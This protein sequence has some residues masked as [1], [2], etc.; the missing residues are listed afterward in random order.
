MQFFAEQEGEWELRVQLNTDLDKMPIEDASVEWP[1]DQSAYLPVARLRI[2]RQAAW[3]E[4][5]STATRIGCRSIRGTASTP[6]G[7]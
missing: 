6:T 2:G 7:R 4:R 3:N 1:E 5:L